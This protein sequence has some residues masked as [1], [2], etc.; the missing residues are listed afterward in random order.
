MNL[1]I[2]NNDI[3]FWVKE[4]LIE[5]KEHEYKFKIEGNW[6]LDP[7]RRISELNT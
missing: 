6:A 3:K 5:E 1:K 7:Y 4:L 2:K